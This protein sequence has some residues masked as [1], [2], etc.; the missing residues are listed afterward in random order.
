MCTVCGVAISLHLSNIEMLVL[1]AWCL[2]RCNLE[3][4]CVCVC[5]GGMDMKRRHY[6]EGGQAGNR[7]DQIDKLIRAMN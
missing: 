1:E 7:E 2:A 3:C 4:V 6:I 5:A